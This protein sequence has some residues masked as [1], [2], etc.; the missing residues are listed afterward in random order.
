MTINTHIASPVLALS[1]AASAVAQLTLPHEFVGAS[2]NDLFGRSVAGIGDVNADGV[3]DLLVGAPWTTVGAIVEAGVARVI[4]GLDGSYLR[5]HTGVAASD[6]FGG[7]VSGAGD[8]DRDGVPDYVIGVQ[9]DDSFAWNAGAAYAYSGATGSLLYSWPGAAVSEYFGTSVSGAGDVNADGHADVIVGGRVAFSGGGAARVYS[10]FD[11]SLLFAYQGTGLEALGD[12]VAAAGDVNA[13]GHDDFLVTASEPNRVFLR[14]GVDGALLHTFFGS[15]GPFGRLSIDS[16]EDIDGDGVP[17]IAVGDTSDS[18]TAMWAG[19]V[20]IYSGASAALLRR[21]YGATAH[22]AFGNALSRAGDVDGDGVGDVLVGAFNDTSAGNGAGRIAIHSGRTGTEIY[23]LAGAP[24]SHFGVSVALAGDVDG[25]G[26]P[27]VL[28]GAYGASPGTATLLSGRHV[29]ELGARFCAPAVPNSAGHPALIH[30]FGSRAVVAND[31]TLVAAQ[32]PP[33]ASG[34]FLASL[35]HG[36]L[37]P[38]GSSGFLCLGGTIG[39]YVGPGQVVFGPVGRLV[40][41]LSAMPVSP[42]RPVVAG[43]SWSFQCWY[44]D[45]LQGSNFTDAVEIM[46]E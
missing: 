5:T 13:D 40:L 35:T 44:R 29:T 28:V 27:D 31:V 36:F 24:D 18:T 37:N 45:G 2:A 41:D 26:R 30:A 8:I 33:G 32:L 42:V 39:R 9:S 23:A 6:S 25:D 16:V 1:L 11:G 19:S 43:E 46:F 4:S 17:E 14:S 7:S 20:S 38:P 21:F 10:G 34:Y 22:G 15:A 12:A 3:P